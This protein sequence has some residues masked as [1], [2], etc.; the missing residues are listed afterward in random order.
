[1]E[2]FGAR[3]RERRVMALATEAV[4]LFSGGLDSTALAKMYRP[5]LLFVDYG[6]TSRIAEQ[7]AARK[8]AALLDLPLRSVQLGIRDFGSGLL[9]GDAPSELAPSPEWWPF[10]NQFLATAGA[11][12]ALEE[13]CASVL[14]GSVAPDGERHRDGTEQFYRLLDS[15]TSFQEGGIRIEAPGI[16]YT[17]EEL[18]RVAEVPHEV[19]AWTFSCHRSDRPCGA[20]PGCWKRQQVLAGL[21]VPGY[22][23][24]TGGAPHGV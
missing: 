2:G 17:T 24:G 21:G 23:W 5:R 9:H 3:T 7:V 4:L 12:V 10:R 13:G 1:M 16:Q 20:C 14:L 19:L 22:D 6:Q 18:V 11:A 8:I 15:L